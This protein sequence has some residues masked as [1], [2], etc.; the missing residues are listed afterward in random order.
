MPEE[1][2]HIPHLSATSEGGRSGHGGPGAP[3]EA[4]SGPRGPG[5][6]PDSPGAGLERLAGPKDSASGTGCL[7]KASPTEAVASAC[8]ARCPKGGQSCDC[9]NRTHVRRGVKTGAVTSHRTAEPRPQNP[10]CAEGGLRVP[11][12]RLSPCPRRAALA[13]IKVFFLPRV[14]WC[15]RTHRLSVLGMCVR[16][17]GVPQPL[18]AVRQLGAGG[19]GAWPPRELRGPEGGRAGG[20]G[21]WTPPQTVRSAS[22]RTDRQ[23]SVGVERPKGEPLTGDAHPTKRCLRPAEPHGATL[24]QKRD[25]RPC[26]SAA[27]LHDAGSSQAPP[28]PQIG[29]TLFDFTNIL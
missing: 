1:E 7:V 20:P 11:G 8:R 27:W 9:E 12:L 17:V 21:L 19:G 22:A 25:K 6:S 29:K 24:T 16:P 14:C 28:P 26:L 15:R 18:P 10:R 2:G 13:P 3:S 4:Q 5:T 23:T